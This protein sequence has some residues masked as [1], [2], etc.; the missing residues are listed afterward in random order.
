MKKSKILTLIVSISLVGSLAANNVLAV[1]KTQSEV[2]KEIEENNKKIEDLEKEKNKVNSEKSEAKD[3][4]ED[5]Q[6]QVNAQNKLLTEK[7]TE[8]KGF[9][10]EIASL[11]GEIDV[12]NNK[13]KE[14]QGN[15]EKN[16]AE[17]TDK[18]NEVKEKQEILD[19]RLRYSY[20]NSVGDRMIYL[21]IDS[22]GLG[23]FISNISNIGTILKTDQKLIEEIE[24]V[25]AELLDKENQLKA[26]ET[27]LNGSIKGIE[28]KKSVVEKSKSKVQELEAVYAA[29]AAKLETVEAERE[30]AFDQLNDEEKK[31]KNEIAQYNQDNADLKAYF[32]N[33]S[34]S[35][36]NNNNNSG[37][38]GSGESSGGDSS[39]SGSSGNQT[40]PPV[41]SQGFIK[42]A[43]GAIT[44]PFGP[45][46][47]PVTGQNSTHTGVDY[48]AANGSNIIASKSGKVTTAGYHTAYGNMIIIDHGSGQSTLYAH[49]SQLKV[50]VGQSVSQGQVI[51]L[52][53]STGYSTGPHLH[54]EVRING[55][56]Q[57]PVNYVR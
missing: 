52:V 34:N 41:S 21:L 19:Q 33:L 50:S 35:N 55:V 51:A 26:K 54:F 36:D 1:A 49:S 23:D 17:I 14:V 13:V 31:I 2:N 40:A 28:D 12:L 18:E 3:K 43:G 4:L 16:K 15:I 5:I 11:Q 38:A 45:R 8:I 48:G 53:G 24:K 57:N 47:H 39:G 6:E 25:K 9:E 37:N 22:K 7:R 42:P 56:P 46:R 29:E 30:K 27:E 32:E 44:S 20:M 10:N